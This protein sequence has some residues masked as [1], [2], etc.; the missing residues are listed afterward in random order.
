MLLVDVDVTRNVM[1]KALLLCGI[2]S[3]LHYVAINVYVPMQWDEYSIASQT[4][5][6]LSAVEAPTRTLWVWIVLPYPLLL[7]A[8]GIGVRL[9]AWSRRSLRIASGAL[10]AH[11]VLGIYWPP[12]HL[13]GEVPEMTLTD[14]LHIVW[15]GVTL[16]LMLV[17]IG[18]GAVA[19]GKR[20]QVSSMLTVIVFAIFGTLAGSK[21][22]ASPR[23]CPRRGSA[24]GRESTLRLSCSGWWCSPSC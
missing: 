7:I 11:G 4:V 17:T 14:T 24:C 5:S 19:L 13:R 21:V 20:F 22:L 2:I 15:A 6:E 9:S 3:S 12:M 8:F 23:T 16:S 1:R 10:I 18:F